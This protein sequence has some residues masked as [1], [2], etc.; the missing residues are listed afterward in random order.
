MRK[1]VVCVQ[2]TCI[3]IY[4]HA[5]VCRYM[6]VHTYMYTYTHIY[7]YICI[8]VYAYIYIYIHIYIHI[9]VY[10]FLHIRVRKYIRSTRN[11][12]RSNY[13]KEDLALYVLLYYKSITEWYKWFQSAVFLAVHTNWLVYS[14]LVGP[15]SRHNTHSSSP[16]VNT[17]KYQGALSKSSSIKRVP[18]AGEPLQNWACLQKKSHISMRELNDAICS[19]CVLSFSLCSILEALLTH[20][21]PPLSP[22]PQYGA[23][24]Q[25]H[26]HTNPR[27]PYPHPH[28]ST[29][30][31]W[32]RIRWHIHIKIYIYT[33]VYIDVSIFSCSLTWRCLEGLRYMYPYV[34][35][36]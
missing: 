16:W 13:R 11:P 7:I 22:Q 29:Q 23:L 27:L 32:Q 1:Y 26:I 15:L 19:L 35:T 8:Y 24:T 5:Y 4:T 10:V 31:R 9:Y 18:V 17:H 25:V 6:H 12:F 21:N 28:T 2:Y 36:S 3:R 20:W 30:P 14:S 33:Y 34:H